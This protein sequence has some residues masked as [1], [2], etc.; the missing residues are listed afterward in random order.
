M[1]KEQLNAWLQTKN[2]TPSQFAQFIGVTPTAVSH[3]LKGKRTIS[4]TV[5]RVCKLMDRHPNLM[6]E[7]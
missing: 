1:N 7:F 4:L 3:W 6:E 5:T 2:L